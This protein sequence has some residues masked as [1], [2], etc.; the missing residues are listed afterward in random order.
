TQEYMHVSP[1]S[2]R[3]YFDD[4]ATKGVKGGFAVGGYSRDTKGPTD[5]YFMLKPDSAKFLLVSDQPADSYSGAL[6][7]TT[8]STSGDDPDQGANL[9]NLTRDNYFIGHRAGEAITF[10]S[11]NSFIGYE[12]GANTT[13]GHS[14]IFIGER[15]GQLNTSGRSNSF[16]G[17]IA[18]QSN[19]DG[20]NNVY[21]GFSAGKDNKSGSHN[22]YIGQEAGLHSLDGFNVFVGDG[23]GTN[24]IK[25]FSNIFLG[26]EAGHHADTSFANIFI[27]QTSGYR[28]SGGA[29]NVL[30]GNV[31]GN[32]NI[33][34]S[35]N[36]FIGHETGRYNKNGEGNT[37]LGAYSGEQNMDA[38]GNV[39]IGLSA[40]RNNVS[41]NAN[42]FV[43]Q[44]TG[45][46]HVS[47]SRNVFIGD[48][49]GFNNGNGESNVF[50][51]AGAGYNNN[52]GRENIFIGFNAGR[53]ETGDGKLYID[54]NNNDS[55]NALIYGE[56]YNNRVQINR[57]LGIGMTATDNALE[58]AGDVSKTSPGDW[59][60]NSDARIKKEVM[61]IENACD[62]ISRLRPVTFR[63][64]EEWM[65]MNPSV[66]DKTYY[67]FIA[68]EYREVFPQ[69]V[70][71]GGGSLEGNE[72]PLL[73]LDSHPANV[74][75]IKAIQE[76]AEQN[77]AQQ[78]IIDELIQKVAALE[79]QING[80]VD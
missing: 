3:M 38:I 44:F 13:T 23:A 21:L 25:G 52:N 64:T 76:L 42:V 79:K 6:S 28:N 15:S 56:F 78:A 19:V 34:G 51:G 57:Q 5:H 53:S 16:I 70:Q 1:D 20:F 27:G 50:I 18:G 71:K 17:P 54:I 77:R 73:Q 41:G 7:V 80:S 22:V 30:L 55:H 48:G 24:H 10:G 33:Y 74:V 66:K 58:V 75:A 26:Q 12:S 47:G 43:G 31:T 63:Y 29:A 68:Q 67:N 8:K 32:E 11:Q 65:Q 59:L 36:T 46:D 60:A 35:N 62:Q 45:W 40:G 2:I 4:E 37:F 39:F 69:S 9:F 61:D 49:S 14:N 72:Q